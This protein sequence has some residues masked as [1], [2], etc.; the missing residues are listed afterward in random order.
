MGDHPRVGGEKLSYSV[1]SIS[2]EGSPPRGRGK[3]KV[4]IA[5][6]PKMGITPAWAGKRPHTC[7]PCA[8]QEDHPRVGGEKLAARRCSAS[9]LGSPP[10]GR[11]KER[12]TALVG[13]P[14]RITPAWAGKSFQRARKIKER[15]DHPRVG[16][17]KS[18]N[19]GV[20]PMWQGSPPRGRGK[21]HVLRPRC[22]RPGIT[23]AWAGKRRSYFPAA[24][25]RGDH[26]RV[27][28]E[29]T[30]CWWRHSC[31]TGSPPRGRG[32]EDVPHGGSLLL[33]ITPAWAGKSCRRSFPA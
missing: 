11:G 30:P 29:K 27:G 22:L 24:R 33:G 18:G 9:I 23:P 17:E 31:T 21:A 4:Q 12:S 32:K 8:A 20:R 25:R 2:R 15:G 3:V 7:G 10:H 16:G 26:P 28:G 19:G 13:T 5:Q 14:T 6:G 1:I